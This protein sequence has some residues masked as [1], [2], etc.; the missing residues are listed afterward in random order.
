MKKRKENK[1]ELIAMKVA[2]KEKEQFQ[3]HAKAAG[4]A[5]VAAYIRYLDTHYHKQI[6]AT[7]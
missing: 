4:F 1:T 2:P 5:S 7:T 6:S 3:E